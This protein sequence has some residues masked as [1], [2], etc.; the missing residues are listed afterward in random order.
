M[1]N[2]IKG[3]TLTITNTMTK[4]VRVIKAADKAQALEWLAKCFRDL[5]R[6]ERAANIHKVK[7]WRSDIYNE[8][9]AKDH[10]TVIYDTFMDGSQ[11]TTYNYEFEGAL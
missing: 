6:S 1:T 2:E 7:Y 4:E 10:F 11:F 9:K 8:P 3:A 5:N